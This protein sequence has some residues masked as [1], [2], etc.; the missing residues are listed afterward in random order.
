MKVYWARAQHHKDILTEGY[1]GVT[2]MTIEERFRFHE[3]QNRFPE[4]Y[5]V[6]VIFEGTEQE[7]LAKEAELRPSWY[8]GWNIAPGGQAGNRPKGIHTSG[9]EHS[10][11][12]KKKRAEGMK[13]NTF[14]A[15]ETFV[16]GIVF[17]QQK[18][19]IA[20][21]KEKYGLSRSKSREHILKGV[22]IKELQ[23]Y[24]YNPKSLNFPN[25]K[26]GA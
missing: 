25:Q 11:E 17:S 26:K 18:E 14:Q 3:K 9:W 7:C 1:V 2:R 19:A 4:P 8:I 20:Y 24:R 15:K 12:S 13:G 5:S 10:E 6:D 21:L 16:D 22:S 23:K